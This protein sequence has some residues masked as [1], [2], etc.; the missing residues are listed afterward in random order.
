M[1]TTKVFCYCR[2]PNRRFLKKTLQNFHLPPPFSFF[3]IQLKILRGNVF[4]ISR[5]FA[6]WLR[7]FYFLLS[8]GKMKPPTQKT[9]TGWIPPDNIPTRK[10]SYKENSHPGQRPP[11]QFPPRKTPTNKILTWTTPTQEISTWGNFHPAN[12]YPG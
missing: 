10:T 5:N 7:I 3:F 1:I 9:A 8:F 11:G 12:W 6:V 4:I 2:G